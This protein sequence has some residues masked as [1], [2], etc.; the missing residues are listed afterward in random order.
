[1]TV[2]L[3]THAFLWFIA[4]DPKLGPRIRAVIEDPGNRV[5]LSIVS[6][7]E[8]VVKVAIG[9]LPL[10]KTIAEVYRDDVQGNDIELLE[11]TVGHLVTLAGLPLVHRDPFDRLLVA[12]ASA[13]GV[14]LVS[15]DP[16]LDAYGIS[17]IW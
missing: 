5:L 10:S 8:I 13:E 15:A 2:L 9:K 12:Q 1:M 3:D 16:A 11:I 4:G 6:L 14:Q 17:R 7:W